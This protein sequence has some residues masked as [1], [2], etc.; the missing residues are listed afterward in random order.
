MRDLEPTKR[1]IVSVVG[2]SYDPLRLLSMA[3]IRFRIDRNQPLMGELLCKWQ[4]L[5]LDLQGAS[6][7]SVPQY[8]LSD[9]GQ[10]EETYCLHR[11]CDALKSAYAVVVY[12]QIQ[13][14]TRTLCEI[15]SIQNVSDPNLG[16]DH[17][18]VGAVITIITC[19]INDKHQ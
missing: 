11:F 12:L 7:I 2:R 16:A 8:F 15:C 13:D 17:P 1:I 18:K 10:E 14:K 4:S 5:I 3:V 6:L 9:T 19:H